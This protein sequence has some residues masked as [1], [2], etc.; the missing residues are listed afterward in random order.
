MLETLGF[1]TRETYRQ[2]IKRYQECTRIES[3]SLEVA[4]DE[5]RDGECDDGQGGADDDYGGYDGGMVGQ[6]LGYRVYK[7]K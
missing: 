2:L 6:E 7:G 5:E 1:A 4:E 3:Y